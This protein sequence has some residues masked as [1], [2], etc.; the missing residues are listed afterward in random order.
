[1]K[2]SLQHLQDHALAIA[3][4]DF[5]SSVTVEGPKELQDLGKAIHTM[6]ECLNEQMH[7]LRE[8]AVLRERMYGEYEC[9]LL[10]QQQ[11][12]QNV[13]D[14]YQNEKYLIK[15]LTF[16]SASALYGVLLELKDTEKGNPEL[17]F[18]EAQEKG[19]TGM[20]HLLAD[21]KARNYY[22]KVFLKN[23]KVE[24]ES[25]DM[26]CPLVWST[27]RSEEIDIKNKNN[28]LETN[29]IIILFNSGL[30]DCFE[31]EEQVHAWFQKVLKHHF[32]S[33]GFDLFLTMLQHELTYL[34][35]KR[36]ISHDIHILCILN[37]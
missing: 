15:A 34:T 11:M 17:T 10:L 3:A 26:A 14:N 2:N 28:I 25:H 1:M 30:Q 12:L 24:V 23:S 20:Y 36:T 31:T 32:A 7:R 8:S 33:E 19:F 16:T 29:D 6:D 9:A 5:K 35:R 22:L 4:G 18:Y 21:P 37:K 13:M 27:T